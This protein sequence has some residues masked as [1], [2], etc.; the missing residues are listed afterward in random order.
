MRHS[1]GFSALEAF[2]HSDATAKGKS[3]FTMSEHEEEG[4]V[5][6]LGKKKG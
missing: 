6:N 1:H 3:L 4:L 5:R 2:F